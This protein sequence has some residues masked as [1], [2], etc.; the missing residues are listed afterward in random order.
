VSVLEQ[1]GVRERV[2]RPVWL[3]REFTL[4]SLP[5]GFHLITD[6]VVGQLPELATIGCGMAQLHIKHTSASLTVNEDLAEEGPDAMP[7]QVES[8]LHGSSVTLPIGDGRLQLGRYQGIYLCEHRGAGPS[9]TL[10]LTAWGEHRH[11]ADAV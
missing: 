1:N 11:S 4:S 5:R 6:E 2:G 3:Q 7:A 8:S 9:R 10:E